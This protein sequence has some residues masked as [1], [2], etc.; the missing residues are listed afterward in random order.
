VEFLFELNGDRFPFAEE[1]ETINFLLVEELSEPGIGSGFEEVFQLKV[2]LRDGSV[3]FGLEGMK[4]F[5]MFGGSSNVFEHGR[6]ESVAGYFLIQ[7]D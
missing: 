6:K 2:T 7:V 3:L 1:G 4:K 5:L